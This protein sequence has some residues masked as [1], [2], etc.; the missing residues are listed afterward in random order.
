MNNNDVYEIINLGSNNPISLKQM[1]EVIGKTLGID[2]KIKQMSMQPGDVDR[3]F[4]D[5]SKAKELLGYNPSV[6]FEEGIKKF[7]E[8][9]KEK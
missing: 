2:P 1:I 5:I 9:Y 3:T 4:A 8:W 7:V 6:S